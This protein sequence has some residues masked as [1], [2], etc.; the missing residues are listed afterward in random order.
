MFSSVAR[1]HCVHTVTLDWAL[2]SLPVES[3]F[4]H[5]RLECCGL[6]RVPQVIPS[7]IAISSVQLVANGVSSYH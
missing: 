7:A 5:A 2:C 4:P 1:R 6:A 3:A